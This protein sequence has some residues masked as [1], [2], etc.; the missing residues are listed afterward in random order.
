MTFDLV[1]DTAPE[2]NEV[3]LFGL[4]NAV[5]ATL[6]D[7]VAIVSI[8]D[9]DGPSTVSVK[10]VKVTE[11]TGADKTAA[12]TVTATLAP[13]PGQDLQGERR[14]CARSRV[15]AERFH[16]RTDHDADVHRRPD[17]QIDQRQGQGRFRSG[18][19]RNLR[20]Q[21]LDAGRSVTRRCVCC[22]RDRLQR[23]RIARR[24]ETVRCGCRH[25]RFVEG[26]AGTATVPVTVTLSYAAT[27]ATSVDVSTANGTAV[28]GA[29]TTTPSHRHP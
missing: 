2:G 24:T 26:N 14:H 3:F 28:E 17:D 21:P 13:G 22:R 16:G 10:D 8:L 27:T 6:G 20:A 5:N 1:G 23:R 7:N 15:F 9:D 25:A 18:R 19:Q 12:F 11:G 4:S 29:R